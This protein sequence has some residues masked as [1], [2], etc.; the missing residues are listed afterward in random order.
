MELTVQPTPET[1]ADQL[2]LLTE[3]RDQLLAQN[4]HRRRQ[5]LL[6]RACAAVCVV[7]AL[8]VLTVCA[9][10][11]PPVTQVLSQAQTVMEALDTELLAATMSDLNATARYGVS[12]AQDAQKAL[13]NF[14][15]ID[16]DTFNESLKDLNAA[17]LQVSELDVGTLNRAIANLNDTIETLARFFGRG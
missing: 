2:V 3:I 10:L 9:I 8:A 13:E 11:L 7:L 12:I 15:E 6:L 5:L 1:S 14:A 4:A 17:L 16:I